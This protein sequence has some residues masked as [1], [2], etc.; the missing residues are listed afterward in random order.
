M[1]QQE[2]NEIERLPEKY[3]PLGAWSYFGYSI[4]F[5]LPLVGW[6]CLLVFAFSGKNIVRRSFA[7]SYFCYALIVGVVAAV[8]TIV[9]IFAGP[10]FLT[11]I[12]EMLPGAPA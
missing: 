10:A 12:M 7:R 4:L 11:R 6:I 3:R 2:K 9:S 1:N 5:A 8:I